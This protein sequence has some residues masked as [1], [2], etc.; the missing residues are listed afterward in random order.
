[1]STTTAFV[2][3]FTGEICFANCVCLGLSCLTL[4]A[5]Y[6]PQNIRILANGTLWSMV[7]LWSALEQHNL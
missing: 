1:M 4:V 2:T 7:K 3:I 5:Y 6:L